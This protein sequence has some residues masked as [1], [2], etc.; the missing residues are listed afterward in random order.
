MVQGKSEFASFSKSRA[1]PYYW[2][3]EENGGFRQRPGVLA[4]DGIRDIFI[5]SQLYAYEC[6][7]AII[8]LMYKAVL[9]TIGDHAFNR[10]FK[11][12]LLYAWNYDEDLKIITRPEGE[13]FQGDVLYFKNP[14]VNPATPE[15]QGENVV[16]LA[17]HLFFGHGMG[18]K[19]ERGIIDGLNSNRAPFA[20]KSAY[21]L[22]QVTQPDF[23]Y[24]YQLRNNYPD[25]IEATEYRYE[26]YI[27]T[28]IGGITA[29]WA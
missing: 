7:T 22:R 26:H 16:V 11:N 1:N 25:G 9:D 20:F 2:I 29:V 4:S 14:Q 13:I 8:I 15:W 10:N 12:L 21:M 27:V 6:A 24:I 5:N 3:R 28:K 19:D 17:D 18:I 23:K